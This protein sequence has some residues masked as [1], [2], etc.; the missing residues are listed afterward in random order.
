MASDS[1]F[2]RLAKLEREQKDMKA[3]NYVKV[4][5]E[6]IDQTV[7]E[8]IYPV[9]TII[10]RYDATDPSEVIG[11][12]WERFAEGRMV[13]G[14]GGSFS[15]AGATGGN[16]SVT[17]TERQL[18]SHSHTGTTNAGGEHTHTVRYLGTTSGS[19]T[20]W[21]G[22]TGSLGSLASSADGEHQHA[23]TTDKTGGGEKIDTMP[24]YVTAYLWRRVK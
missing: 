6:M 14:V 1:V 2:E 13:L 18:P 15:Q 21:I 10:T 20:G 8:R 11:G 22:S 4:V 24:P 7:L 16:Q 5:R 12:E 9:G 3:S 17:L 19:A 23:F